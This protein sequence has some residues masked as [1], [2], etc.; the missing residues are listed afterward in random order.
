MDSLNPQEAATLAA[1]LDPA[2]AS[3]A[4]VAEQ[5]QAAKARADALLRE[6]PQ[7]QIELCKAWMRAGPRARRAFI[8]DIIAAEPRLITEITEGRLI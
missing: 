7:P 1:A 6:T 3:R 2:A 5:E 8:S 4:A